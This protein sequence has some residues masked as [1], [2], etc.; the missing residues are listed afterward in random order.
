MVVPFNC[1]INGI[2]YKTP[3]VQSGYDANDNR[4]FSP[5]NKCG[6]QLVFS[7]DGM[8]KLSSNI[9]SISCCSFIASRHLPMTSSHNSA[10][11]ILKK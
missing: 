9:W 11:I 7:F 10:K 1:R 2:A 5:T 6:V 8:T 4:F 3:C